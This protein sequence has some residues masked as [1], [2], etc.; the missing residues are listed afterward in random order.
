ML[1]ILT[2][3]TFPCLY[4][5]LYLSSIFIVFTCG[6]PKL[7]STPH[8][9]AHLCSTH[10]PLINRLYCLWKLAT[11]PLLF[12][13]LHLLKVRLSSN[14]VVSWA[15]RFLVWK[16]GWRMK[17]QNNTQENSLCLTHQLAIPHAVIT[18][19]FGFPAY[20]WHLTATRTDMNN[21]SPKGIS[22][23]L[24]WGENKWFTY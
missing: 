13:K 6:T 17:E 12:W 16:A 18:Q 14:T 24:F 22:I 23:L 4:L 19:I 15:T 2:F 11:S 20:I 10:C 5:Y 21:G 9:R 8:P 1:L 7:C 3:S